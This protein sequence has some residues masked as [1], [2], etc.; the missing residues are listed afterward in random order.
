M[1]FAGAGARMMTTPSQPRGKVTA[2]RGT[3]IVGAFAVALVASL[4]GW[5]G[6]VHADA[7]DSRV[8]QLRGSGDYKVRLTAALWLSKKRDERSVKAFTQALRSDEEHTIR[9]L[10]AKYLGGN[11]AAAKS[12]KARSKALRALKR[13]AKRDSNSKVREAA[14][15]ALEQIEKGGRILIN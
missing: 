8:A 12:A 11:L 5:I 13:A 6:P 15:S 1:E 14:R 10:A 4:I 3:G 7:I 2:M 9:Q